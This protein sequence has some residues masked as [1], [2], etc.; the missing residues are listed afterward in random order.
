M[1]CTGYDGFSGAVGAF[2]VEIG[3]LDR[4]GCNLGLNDGEGVGGWETML[5][6]I[7]GSGR[8]GGGRDAFSVDYAGFSI[9]RVVSGARIGVEGGDEGVGGTGDAE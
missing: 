9:N 4:D 1:V 7:G 8:V 2:G 3:V 6:Y 5:A